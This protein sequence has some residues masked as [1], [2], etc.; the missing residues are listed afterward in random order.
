[1]L[2]VTLRSNG[3]DEFY[4]RNIADF[5]DAGFKHLINPID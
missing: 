3:V 2:A 4:T 5:R 1:V